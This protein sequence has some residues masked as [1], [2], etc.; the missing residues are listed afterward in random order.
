MKG[1]KK[2]KAIAEIFMTKI[3]CKQGENK[4]NLGSK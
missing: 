2:S 4:Q 3:A 1:G